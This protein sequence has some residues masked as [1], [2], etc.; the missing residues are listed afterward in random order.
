MTG[1]HPRAQD[2]RLWAFHGA[3]TKP[4]SSSILAQYPL[5]HVAGQDVSSC[6]LSHFHVQGVMHW[7]KEHLSVWA[8]LEVQ[9]FIGGAGTYP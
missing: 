1:L 5:K 6:L 3:Q 4:G 8:L 9:G 2:H 7:H